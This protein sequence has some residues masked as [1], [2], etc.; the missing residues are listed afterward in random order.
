MSS[1]IYLIFLLS[2]A[3]ISPT[4]TN[5]A[6]CMLTFLIYIYIYIN[7]DSL[8]WFGL[9]VKIKNTSYGKEWNCY[10]KCCHNMVNNVTKLPI[11]HTGLFCGSKIPLSIKQWVLLK[12]GVIKSNNKFHLSQK[13]MNPLNHSHINSSYFTHIKL[14][15]S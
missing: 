13:N 5:M 14:F 6:W 11:N 10:Y 3:H 8:I 7:Q 15:Y 9:F 1:F 4:L 12:I 2:G